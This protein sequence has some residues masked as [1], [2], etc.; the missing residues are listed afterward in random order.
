MGTALA[1]S[2]KLTNLSQVVH[3]RFYPDVR[4]FDEST[5]K[6]AEHAFMVSDAGKAER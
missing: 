3:L 1:A 5:L 4:G 6:G 2:H